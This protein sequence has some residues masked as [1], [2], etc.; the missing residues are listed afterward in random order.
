MVVCIAYLKTKIRTIIWMVVCIVYLHS[1]FSYHRTSFKMY[2]NARTNLDIF[3]YME[4]NPLH[5]WFVPP[6]S[7]GPESIVSLQEASI[8]NVSS[9]SLRA[10]VVVLEEEKTKKTWKR[11]M[12]M[13]CR[14]FHYLSTYLRYH[15]P[16]P[17]I[18]PTY[19]IIVK[20]IGIMQSSLLLI[21][22]FFFIFWRFD[23]TTS[24][25]PHWA[26]FS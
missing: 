21:H 25:F 19:R 24:F 5:R 4:T 26:L 13:W 15:L 20:A 10:V 22:R 8:G 7:G 6:S 12:S 23:E 16:K 1:F 17:S 2:S 18:L 14:F 3:L 11:N 9:S